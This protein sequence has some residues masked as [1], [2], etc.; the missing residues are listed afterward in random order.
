MADK[1]K[2]VLSHNQEIDGKQK[3]AGDEISLDPSLA[4]ALANRGAVKVKSEREAAKVAPAT[5]KEAVK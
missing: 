2:V 5:P 3:K 4:R 1:V